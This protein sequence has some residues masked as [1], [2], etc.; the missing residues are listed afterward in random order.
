MMRGESERET[1]IERLYHREGCAARARVLPFA[2]RRVYTR[3][4][5]NES[6]N[7][8]INR[9]PGPCSL[10]RHE[11]TM[12]S[13]HHLTKEGVLPQRQEP[14]Q[15]LICS[16]VAAVRLGV[17]EHIPAAAGELRE[18]CSYAGL[19]DGNVFLVPDS[20]HKGG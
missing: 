11:L 5:A 17:G 15:G 16:G 10:R 3:Q 13:V 2:G 6:R 7:V 12:R 14:R 9:Q 20:H 1:D 19:H 8:M 4:L 18:S